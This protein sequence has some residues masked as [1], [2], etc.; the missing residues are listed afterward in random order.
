[1]SKMSS[2]SSLAFWLSIALIVV[3]LG[4]PPAAR[5]A[6]APGATLSTEEAVPLP[7]QLHIFYSQLEAQHVPTGLLL[8]AGGILYA[9]T[10][11]SHDGVT[12]E[13]SLEGWRRRGL[14]RK[15]FN[16][17]T[18]ELM[19][20]HIIQEH[21]SPLS[22]EAFLRRRS[23][24]T[25]P[26]R[27][28]PLALAFVE[29]DTLLQ[30]PLE[31]TDHNG[32][33]YL[34]ATD[35]PIGERRLFV[36]STLQTDL[37]R[38]DNS[39]WILRPADIISNLAAPIEDL[40]LEWNGQSL[41]IEIDQPFSVSLDGLEGERIRRFALRFT[42]GGVDY[43]AP[44]AFHHRADGADG[45]MPLPECYEMGNITASIPFRGE[46]ARINLRIYPSQ[47]TVSG[48]G[49]NP[50]GCAIGS[51]PQLRQ[52]LVVVDGFD[53]LDNRNQDSIF[54]D[55]GEGISGFVAAGFD[56]VSVDYLDGRDYIQRNG[57][58]VREFLVSRLPNWMHPQA[59]PRVVVVAGSMG[60]QT[61][62][63]ALRTAELAGEDHHTALFVAIDSPFQG[64]NIPISLQALAEF[65]SFSCGGV[66]LVDGLNSP[67]AAQQLMRN[68]FNDPILPPGESIN[69][70]CYEPLWPFAPVTPVPSDRWY[71]PHPEYFDY[72]SE[73]NALGLP[74]DS[75]NV[76][77]ASGSGT[78]SPTP[79][80][81]NTSGQF[82]HVD[83]SEELLGVTVGR[84]FIDARVD[85]PGRAFRGLIQNAGCWFLDGPCHRS[86]TFELTHGVELDMVPGGLRRSPLDIKNSWNQNPD[87][88][89]TM[90]SRQPVHNF[91]PTFSALNIT[92]V[93]LDYDPSEDPTALAR[94]GFDTIWWEKCNEDHVERTDGMWQFIQQELGAFLQGTIPGPVALA[95]NPCGIREPG[96]PI[97][98]C[99]R[100]IDSGPSNDPWYVDF[101]GTGSTDEGGTIVEYRWDFG[102]GSPL[103]YGPTVYH[104][105]HAIPGNP[106]NAYPTLTITDNDGNQDT[107]SCGAFGVGTDR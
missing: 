1:M 85:R 53:P 49:G 18:A 16:D 70:N 104:E 105:Y 5:G 96:V 24:I 48:S 9:D 40:R 76:G 7:D 31:D 66:E 8:E 42:S 84:V 94:S 39:S 57:L 26:V 86:W 75:R 6:A 28:I 35:G 82:N 19:R 17:V 74:S 91:V 52:V 72:Y 83:W 10:I 34:P 60:G 47:G 71:L 58:A 56:V 38:G 14:V 20:G 33:H 41:P 11:L 32:Q 63:Y 29:Y 13:N 62:R 73:V 54:D 103:A 3:S 102:D 93:S 37:V 92:G 25:S 21:D 36:A 4:S 88:R 97:A 79:N 22:Q 98:H 12:G 59:D 43:E 87:S 89:G 61:S 2:K 30:A 64:A 78:G 15:Q 90:T 27:A 23:T 67:A 77:I 100:E 46:N 107:A 65:L 68:R 81:N 106:F 51:N 95:E 69:P 101:I 45:R 50:Q 80:Y 44:G 99:H 55:F